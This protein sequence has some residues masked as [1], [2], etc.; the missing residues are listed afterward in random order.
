MQSPPV[1]TSSIPL[2]HRPVT[3]VCPS[4]EY[5]ALAPV[6]RLL[7]MAC[8]EAGTVQEMPV[9]SYV[10]ET[11]TRVRPLVGRLA[12]KASHDVHWAVVGGEPPMKLSEYSCLVLMGVQVNPSPV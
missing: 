5:E 4:Q 6:L 7:A 2:V 10:P 8:T 11:V 9:V 3:Q 1:A 12:R